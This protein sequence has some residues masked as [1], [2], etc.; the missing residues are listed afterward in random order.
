MRRLT[1][2]GGSSAKG[3]NM[4]FVLSPEVWGLSLVASG[5]CGWVFGNLQGSANIIEDQNMAD[6]DFDELYSLIAPPK[7]ADQPKAVIFQSNVAT[8]E[9]ETATDIPPLSELRAQVRHI[10]QND[11]VWDTDD[12][13]DR[14]IEFMRTGDRRSARLLSQY[15]NSIESLQR[16]SATGA[17]EHNPP[18]AASGF[19]P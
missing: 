10:L 3:L 7:I 15:R 6:Q 4:E 12:S 9:C 18:R 16:R 11:N 13:G 5:Y 1:H 19:R 2:R 8:P 14:L 17:A